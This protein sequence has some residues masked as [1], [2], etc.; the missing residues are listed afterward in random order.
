MF[1]MINPTL[2][3]TISPTANTAPGEFSTFELVCFSVLSLLATIPLGIV[4]W[5]CIQARRNRALEESIANRSTEF[6]ELN[7]PLNLRD[8]NHTMVPILN[9]YGTQTAPAKSNIRNPI[10]LLQASKVTLK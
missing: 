5:K 6:Q 7:Y 2:S 9:H 4:F 8:Q 3:P 1:S 10:V